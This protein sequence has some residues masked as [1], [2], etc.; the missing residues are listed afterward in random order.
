SHEPSTTELVLL[1]VST[2]QSS[3]DSIVT[4]TLSESTQSTQVA[5]ASVALSTTSIQQTDKMDSS[6][7]VQNKTLT[8]TLAHSQF[9]Q[10]FVP[11]SEQPLAQETVSGLVRRAD[12]KSQSLLTEINEAL[13]ELPIETQSKYLEKISEYK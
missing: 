12:E 5:S 9:F 11:V 2:T 10:P 6:S 3:T 1:S 4:S 8:G 7:P 13:D